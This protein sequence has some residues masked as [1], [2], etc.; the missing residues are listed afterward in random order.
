MAVGG[1]LPPPLPLDCGADCDTAQFERAAQ[2]ALDASAGR[3][4]TLPPWRDATP[5]TQLR[6]WGPGETPGRAR[7]ERYMR[8]PVNSEQAE[9]AAAEQAPAP[10]RPEAQAA[11]APASAEA[12]RPT[13]AVAEPAAEE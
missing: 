2:Y 7:L 10:A 3:D 4:P 5:T 12:L 13:A 8:Y 6:P 9:R 1:T 11:S